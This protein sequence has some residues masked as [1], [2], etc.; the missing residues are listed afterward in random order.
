MMSGEIELP[1]ACLRAFSLMN[2][3]LER[4]RVIRY[5]TLCIAVQCALCPEFEGE[6]ERG[7]LG[8]S[9][10]SG[11]AIPREC[12]RRTWCVRGARF[13]EGWKRV[14]GKSN[15]AEIEGLAAAAHR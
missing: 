11:S 13:A 7:P 8:S 14:S 6:A 3:L 2:E 1:A 5:P 9:E 4:A 12:T 10:S 15:A